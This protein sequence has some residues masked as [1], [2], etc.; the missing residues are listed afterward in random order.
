MVFTINAGALR[1]DKVTTSAELRRL[2][3]RLAHMEGELSKKQTQVKLGFN[4]VR[5]WLALVTKFEQVV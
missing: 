5:D 4:R 3:A 1:A 2:Q